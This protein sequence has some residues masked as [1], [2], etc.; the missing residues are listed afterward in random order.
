MNELVATLSEHT[1]RD[2]PCNSTIDD[3]T[4]T[5]TKEQIK[6]HFVP[7]FL[8]GKEG[9]TPK[10]FVIDY[11]KN[12]LASRLINTGVS[13]G[14]RLGSALTYGVGAWDI[15]LTFNRA[16]YLTNGTSQIA[17][18][19]TSW[20]SSLIPQEFKAIIAPLTTGLEIG[21]SF[22]R[23]YVDNILYQKFGITTDVAGTVFKPYPTVIMETLWKIHSGYPTDPDRLIAV[24]MLGIYGSLA[25]MV[26]AGIMYGAIGLGKHLLRK[27]GHDDEGHSSRSP[28]GV[29]A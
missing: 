20:M 17:L 19:A 4:Q 6:K 26:T 27:N 16:T 25:R 13:A 9:L 23:A 2:T 10:E 28:T 18:E 21:V 22:I 24:N 15:N 5:I 7:E 12:G 11:I 3:M 8:E 1:D 14:I 29:S